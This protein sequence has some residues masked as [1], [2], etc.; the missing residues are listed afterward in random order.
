MIIGKAL[1]LMILENNKVIKKVIEKI[2]RNDIYLIICTL[3]IFL[4]ILGASLYKNSGTESIFKLFLWTSY[5]IVA[6][7][8]FFDVLRRKYK[9]IELCVITLITVIL[10]INMRMTG[11]KD[12]LIY[13]FFILGSKGTDYKRVVKW[14]GIAHFAA[15]FIVIGSCYADVL[16][17]VIYIHRSRIRESLGFNYTTEGANFYFYSVLLWVY[18]RDK[19]IRWTELGLLV[20]FDVFL[21]AKTGTQSAFVLSIFVLCLVAVAKIVPNICIWKTEYYWITMLLVPFM[22]VFI[23]YTTCKFDPSVAWLNKLD[24]VLNS[25]LQ[26][27]HAAIEKYGVPVFGQYIRWVGGANVFEGKYNYVDS[28][29][30][31]ILINYG[32]VFFCILIL[33]L[34]CFERSICNKKDF[35]LLIVFS[36]F[37]IHATFDPQL[38]WIM[39]NT[40]WLAYTYVIGKN[41]ERH[42]T[43][44]IRNKKWKV[45][46]ATFLFVFFAWSVHFTGLR[47]YLNKALYLDDKHPGYIH[48]LLDAET[49]YF[50]S[51]TD[52]RDAHLLTLVDKDGFGE[53]TP[54]DM[55]FFVE[56]SRRMHPNIIRTSLCFS[57]DTGIEIPISEPENAKYGGID[58]FGRV[59]G[60]SVSVDISKPLLGQ[61]SG[62]TL[63]ERE[64]DDNMNLVYQFRKGADGIGI[65]DYD[66][67]AGF[68]RVYDKRHHIISQKNIGIDKKPNINHNGFSEFRREFEGENLVWEGYFDLE[69]KLVERLDCLYAVVIKEY[70]RKHNCIDEKYFDINGNMT[71]S[72]Y[73]YAEIKREYHGIKI[74]KES[75][76]DMQ[77]N[78]LTLPEG[79]TSKCFG[80]NDSG[81]IHTEIFMDENNNAILTSFG[82]AE[83]RRSYDGSDIVQEQYFGP[84][85]FPLVRAG[86]YAAIS[87]KW[88]NGSLKSRTYLDKDCNPVERQDGYSTVIWEQDE[89]GIKEV[90]FQGVLGEPVSIE[91]INLA[92]NIGTNA[93]GWSAWMTPRQNAENYCFNIGYANL[94]PKAEGD[95]YSSQVEIEFKGV[96]SEPGKQFL[97]LTQGAQDGKWTAGNVWNGELVNLN[98]VP[99]DGVYSFTSTVVIDDNMAKVSR[100]DLGFRC[101][102]WASGS[103]RV[104]NVKVEKGDTATEWSPGI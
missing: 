59:L 76:F 99:E 36:T 89:D 71:N 82:Y 57:D 31:Q 94:G 5:F 8:I 18:A 81:K 42:A 32:W 104:R 93:D 101:D 60:T 16:D 28:S 90:Q 65:G 38:I 37:I 68:Y 86:G 35:Y 100:F 9:I 80:Y 66:G 75:Y 96:S 58:A 44:A 25:R 74:S 26:L 64:Y 34:L 69:G 56:A 84:D 15:L 72:S 73:G 102:Y 4:R 50:E 23:L 3:Y 17:N 79:Y 19:K 61:I 85:G 20:L 47:P 46:V 91:K 87:Q 29:F 27:G 13:W 53:V 49:K 7:I 39:F 41:E 40:F 14:V 92:T 30:V 54:E 48:Q 11:I 22:V 88:E 77:G 70:D 78:P 33:G 51:D 95:S 55:K 98:E 2:N 45:G 1:I 103:F 10:F 24:Q 63:L 52:D 6:G 21:F 83:V 67:N 97:F 12:V 43:S 62:I